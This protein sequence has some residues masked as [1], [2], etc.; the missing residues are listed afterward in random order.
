M[1]HASHHSTSR[2]AFRLSPQA[3]FYLQASLT[4]SFL[5][6]S[7]APTP[8]YPLYQQAWGFSP[9]AITFVFGIYALAVLAALLVAGRLSDHVGRKPV[10]IVAAL[11]QV[12]TMILFA[13]ASGLDALIAARIIQGLSTG[14]AIAAIGAGLLDIDRER[15]TIANAIAPMLGTGLGA[16]SAGLMV[17]Y[18][19]APTHAVYLVLGTI[20]VLQMIGIV[21]MPETAAL[22]PGALASLKPQIAFG[23]KVRLPLLFATPV[24]IAVWALA[25]LYGSLGPAMIRSMLSHDSSLLGG[26]ALFVLAASGVVGVLVLHRREA[27]AMMSR[28]AIGLI[29]GVTI[30]VAA[31]SAGNAPAFFLGTAIAGVGFGTG[32]QG[33]IRTVLPLADAKDRAGVLSV[34]LVVS[35]L[36]LGVP[37]VLAG[38]RVSQTGEILTTVQ[39]FGAA[40]I[41]LAAV[42]LLGTLSQRRKAPA[43]KTVPCL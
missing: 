13:G 3:A 8:L 33:A 26:L 37:A 30:S 43:A 1:N 24:L 4:V 15:G 20:F 18:L 31:F 16:I 40:I 29:V 9:V 12:A 21:L 38:Y 7:S 2:R 42:A 23:A 32:F 14:A 6:G 10:L 28:G 35:Y 41:A 19:P 36:S 11:V 39:I 25:G 17:S 5:A 34:M 27:H 22:R